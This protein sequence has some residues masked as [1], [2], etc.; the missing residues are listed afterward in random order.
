[1]ASE[2]VSDVGHVRGD[3]K[4]KGRFVPYYRVTLLGRAAPAAVWSAATGGAREWELVA[5]FTEIESGKRPDRTKAALAA[6]N[7]GA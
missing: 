4:H 3:T 1:M 6:A 2:S 5:E 7:G